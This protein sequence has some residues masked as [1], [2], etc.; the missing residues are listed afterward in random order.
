M[1]QDGGDW[2]TLWVDLADLTPCLLP[3][4]LPFKLCRTRN[5]ARPTSAWAVSVSVTH[6][7][8]DV[9]SCFL[10]LLQSHPL[11]SGVRSHVHIGMTE[12]PMKC[13]LGKQKVSKNPITPL[14]HGKHSEF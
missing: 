5:G 6:L 14:S 4:L 12:V 2:R 8:Y 7:F 10:P 3:N 1:E 9:K 13:R 11:A